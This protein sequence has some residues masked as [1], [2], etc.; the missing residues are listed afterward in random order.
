MGK[1]NVLSNTNCYEIRN[2]TQTP[3]HTKNT[4][5]LPPE[6]QG[7]GN[8]THPHTRKTNTNNAKHM[9]TKTMT[10]T[11]NAKTYRK[12]GCCLNTG[13]IFKIVEF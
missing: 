12:H 3:Q 2:A 5:E 11:E 8:S 1:L 6:N 9:E 13:I 4:K 10:Q 7:S